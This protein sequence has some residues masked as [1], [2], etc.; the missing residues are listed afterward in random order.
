[1]KILIGAYALMVV[2]AFAAYLFGAPE[3]SA[4]GAEAMG[5]LLTF[6]MIGAFLYWLLG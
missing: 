6:G 3:I 5:G 2:V 4:R 1:M